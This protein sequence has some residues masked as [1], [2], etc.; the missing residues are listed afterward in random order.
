MHKRELGEARREE[1]ER[2]KEGRNEER[3]MQ[4]SRRETKG[5]SEKAEKKIRLF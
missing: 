5:V 4:N 2:E 3:V 1:R